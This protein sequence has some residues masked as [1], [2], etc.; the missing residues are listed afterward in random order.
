MFI[1]RLLLYLIGTIGSI[2][3]LASD[4]PIR[5]DSLRIRDPFIYTHQESNTYLMYAQTGNR[6]TSDFIGVEVYTSKDLILWEEP[7]PVLVLPKEAGIKAVW[8]PEMHK[9]N[10]KYYLFVTLTYHQTLPQKIPVEKKEWPEMHIR[11]THIFYANNPYGPFKSLKSDSFTPK[12]WMALDGTLWIEDRTPYMVFCHEWIQLIDGTMNYVQLKNDLSDIV[13]KPHLLFKA[14][15]APGAISSPEKGKVTDGC[16]LYRSLKTKRLFMI[17]STFI[18]GDGY[19]VMATSSESGKISGPWQN[20]TPIY[21][22]N[23]GHGMIF[24]SFDE[25]LLMALHQPN[26]HNLERLHLFEIIDMGE[27]LKV[28]EEINIR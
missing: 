7:E 27:I 23:G 19:C 14:S 16:F 17:W 5:A 20:H 6:S 1:K 18:P 9:Y 8:A 24:K 28:G 12:D 2:N 25:K 15:D 13:G 21:T 26:S 4:T 3:L 10:E 22:K 11:G